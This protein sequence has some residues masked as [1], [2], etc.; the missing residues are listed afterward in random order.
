[1]N[2]AWPEAQTLAAEALRV[3]LS[4]EYERDIEEHDIQTFAQLSG[5]ANPLHLDAEYARRTTFGN[6]IVHGAFQLGLASAMAGMH[7]PGRN[8]LLGSV[9]A[10]FPSPL[11]YPCRVRVRGTLMSWNS[12]AQSGTLK[13]MVYE[14]KSQTPTADIAMGFTFHAQ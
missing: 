6:R 10:K 11:Y 8:V 12:T 2:S 5:D 4:A 9:Q 1:M 7:L 13:V 3:G 14:A